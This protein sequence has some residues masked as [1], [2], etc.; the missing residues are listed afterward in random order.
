MKSQMS[1]A[2]IIE[3]AQNV[4]INTLCFTALPSGEHTAMS[5][6]LFNV[7]TEA[8]MGM[9]VC[10]GDLPLLIEKGRV[11]CDAVPHIIRSFSA[12]MRLPDFPADGTPNE[13]FSHEAWETLRRH[14]RL[15]LRAMGEELRL[16]DRK[17]I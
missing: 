2:E 17:Y 7:L 5:K 4:L 16:P 13:Y 9:E 1:E 14:S 10:L 15:A 3:H 6:P 12:A 11:S 8:Y